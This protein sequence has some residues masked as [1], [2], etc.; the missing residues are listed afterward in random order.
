MSQSGATAL[1]T[2]VETIHEIWGQANQSRQ[3]SPHGPLP[4]QRP[5]RGRIPNNTG[6]RT[7][8]AEN[9]DNRE[10]HPLQYSEQTPAGTSIAVAPVQTDN[11]SGTLECNCRAAEQAVQ[12]PAGASVPPFRTHR[13]QGLSLALVSKAARGAKLHA[14]GDVGV[15]WTLVRPIAICRISVLRVSED[16]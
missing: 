2:L 10:N 14:A 13:Y 6:V 8:L 11:S 4:G 12:R 15:S 1:T 7:T 3:R 16:G 9:R 5:Q